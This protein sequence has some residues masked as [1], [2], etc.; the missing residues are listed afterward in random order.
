MHP[1]VNWGAHTD[2][3]TEKSNL[4]S[5]SKR[6]A[7]GRRSDVD[8]WALFERM[9]LDNTQYSGLGSSEEEYSDYS[10]NDFSEDI[11]SVDDFS[12]RGREM[13]I[14]KNSATA[15]SNE[16][17]NAHYIWDVARDAINS[18]VVR[19]ALKITL[20]Y[21]ITVSLAC[22]IPGLASFPRS[23]GVCPAQGFGI[24][25]HG[26]NLPGFSSD[27]ALDFLGL[28]PAA[29]P[30][31]QEEGTNEIFSHYRYR[32]NLIDLSG[33]ANLSTLKNRDQIT[34]TLQDVYVFLP[35]VMEYVVFHNL[36]ISSCSTNKRNLA[37]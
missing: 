13:Q 37:L 8:E 30:I 20:G 7:T 11:S 10:Q 34:N 22:M 28:C 21:L 27:Y 19:Y 1:A 31:L 33:E 4:M 35:L 3:R 9:N 29:P 26:I 15:S 6:R 36:S 18:P 14:Y 25:K 23:A 2:I 17:Y 24:W 32:I 5:R 12:V 16:P